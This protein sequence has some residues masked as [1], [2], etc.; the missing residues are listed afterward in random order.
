MKI[1]FV[2]DD[3]LDKVDGVQQ[4]ILTLGRWLKSEGHQVH[5]LV[6]ETKRT[7]IANVHSLSKNLQVHFNQ[8][9]MSTPLPA[10]KSAIKRLLSQKQFDVLHVQLP[11]SPFL[12]GRVISMA[13]KT[14]AI[15]GTFHIIPVSWREQIA[16]RVLRLLVA[17]SRRR[18]DRT[19][20]VSMPA[21]RFAKKA[22]GLQATVLPNA[23]AIAHYH[24]A[25]QLPRYSDGKINI[26]FLGRLVERKGCMALLKAI[27]L[28]HS[29]NELQNVRVLICGKGPLEHHLKEFVKYHH[30][31]HVV[32]FCGFVSE[33]QKPRFLATANIAVMPSTGGESFGI[34]LVEAM[35]AGAEVVIG[36]DNI[37]YRTVLD[38][39]SDQLV[40]PNDTKTFARKLRR[41]IRN[42]RARKAVDAWQQDW[43]QQFDVRVVG[44][45]LIDE[46]EDV[47]AKRK[48]A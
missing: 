4:Y 36:G 39:R 11:H 28:L 38:N 30:L 21:A 45:Q 40:N 27:E 3:S 37:G 7:D 31:S 41:F 8:N 20:A 9:R 35:A 19:F 25:N 42:P 47:I 46:Y 17:R 44:Q 26:V 22:Y 29:K 6:G 15:F 2:L 13:P 48:T 24:G 23:V 18:I 32:T 1:G 14:T 43:V 5:Y 34:V 12:A 33:Q 10:K 16:T